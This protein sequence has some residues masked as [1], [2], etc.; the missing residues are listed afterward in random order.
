VRGWRSRSLLWDNRSSALP[1]DSTRFLIGGALAIAFAGVVAS[2]CGGVTDPSQNV[3]E[4]FTGTVPVRGSMFSP[5]S[6]S[7]VGEFS[8][9]LI[10]LSPPASVFVAVSFGVVLGGTICSPTQ[11]P[12]TLS[13][14]G[15]TVLN[16]QIATPGTYCIRVDDE[17]FFTVPETY[18][19]QVAHP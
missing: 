9:T 2:G 3:T 1:R 8:V 6:S 15:H 18:T 10:S 12:N 14:A 16:G 11:Q 7:R 4:T 13:T 5:F 19:I 17:G